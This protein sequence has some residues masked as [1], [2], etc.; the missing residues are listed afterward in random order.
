MDNQG[1]L[2]LTDFGLSKIM[3]DPTKPLNTFCG[4]PYYLAPEM[5]VSK[6]GYDKNVDWWSCGII[7]FEMIVGQ[8]PFFSNEMQKV[9]EKMSRSS[10]SGRTGA[11]RQRAAG[12]S[13]TGCWSATRASVLGRRGAIR[14]SRPTRSS[15]AWTG[16]L[17]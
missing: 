6:K 5:L 13:S 14:R 10:T 15:A 9:Y 8:L 12:Q 16:R 17:C 2:H 3:E 4:T 7:I 11:Q 1:N